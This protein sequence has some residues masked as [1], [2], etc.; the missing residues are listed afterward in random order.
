MSINIIMKM[1]MKNEIILMKY[2]VWNNNNNENI[3]N[4]Q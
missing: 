1:S 3:N 4:N 2:N